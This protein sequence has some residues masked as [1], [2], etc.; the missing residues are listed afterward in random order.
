M[1]TMAAIHIYEKL[2]G[3]TVNDT[4]TT[5]KICKQ[6]SQLEYQELL[7][8]IKTLSGPLLHVII[9]TPLVK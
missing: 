3:A 9:K 7:A 6:T 5:G 2:K 8:V 4:H 1:V